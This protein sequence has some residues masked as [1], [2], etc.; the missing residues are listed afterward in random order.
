MSTLVY[1]A[2]SYQSVYE[3][4]ALWYLYY[5]VYSLAKVAKKEDRR[6]IRIYVVC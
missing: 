2:G 4:G 3:G 5:I 6:E 1:L